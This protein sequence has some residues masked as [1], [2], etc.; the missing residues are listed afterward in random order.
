LSDKISKKQE[1]LILRHEHFV[2]YENT[3]NQKY[4]PVF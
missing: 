2:I 3:L 4:D 1:S